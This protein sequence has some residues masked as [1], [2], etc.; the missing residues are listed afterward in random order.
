MAPRGNGYK[1]PNLLH[2]WARGTRTSNPSRSGWPTWVP[3]TGTECPSWGSSNASSVGVDNQMRPQQSRRCYEGSNSAHPHDK[4]DYNDILTSS[5]SADPLV[6][7]ASRKYR[8]SGSGREPFQAKQPTLSPYHTCPQR[9]RAWR[10]QR[11]QPSGMGMA[12][13]SAN[14]RP[15]MSLLGILER[16]ERGCG[17]PNGAPSKVSTVAEDRTH[18]TWLTCRN[19]HLSTTTRC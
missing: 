15:R 11:N 10:T 1:R 7:K 2:P 17:Q 6:L 18:V 13:M 4:R 16:I 8:K 5:I 3:A 19:T 9:P 14:V 12:N